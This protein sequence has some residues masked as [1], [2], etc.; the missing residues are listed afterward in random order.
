M[1]LVIEFRSVHSCLAA[2][3]SMLIWAEQSV[4]E[5]MM[6]IVAGVLVLVGAV[7]SIWQFKKYPKDLQQYEEPQ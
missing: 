6:V 1:V 4:E 3:A 2:A 7:G 5:R